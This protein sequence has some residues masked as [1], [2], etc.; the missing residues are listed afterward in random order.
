MVKVISIV[1]TIGR[2]KIDRSEVLVWKYDGDLFVDSWLDKDPV[3]L[4]PILKEACGA[5]DLEVHST[6]GDRATV[7]AYFGKG[8]R[9]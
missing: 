2:R 1:F 9:G 6:A 3:K 8:T 7:S 5:L 4:A